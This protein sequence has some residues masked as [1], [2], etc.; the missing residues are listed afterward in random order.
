MVS[1]MPQL[2]YSQE[3]IPQFPLT[4]RLGGPQSQA[5]HFREE[6]NLKPLSGIK[7]EFLGHPTSSQP[8]C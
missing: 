7:T 5:G 3:Y 2:L 8:L 4:V 1:F 6:K